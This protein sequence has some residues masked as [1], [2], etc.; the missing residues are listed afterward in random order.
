MHYISHRRKE[1][2]I[3]PKKLYKYIVWYTTVPRKNPSIIYEISYEHGKYKT[4]KFINGL[5]ESQE[6]FPDFLLCVLWTPNKISNDWNN[7]L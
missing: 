5:E 7:N 2:P 1:I 3:F 4:T 6:I